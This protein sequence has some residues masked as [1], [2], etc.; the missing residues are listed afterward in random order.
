MNKQNKH[1][2]FT[3]TQL[4]FI[5]CRCLGRRRWNAYRIGHSFTSLL[6]YYIIHIDIQQK[7]PRAHKIIKI[8]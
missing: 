4:L 1:Y 5:L 7:P 3:T 2:I 6:L 8:F